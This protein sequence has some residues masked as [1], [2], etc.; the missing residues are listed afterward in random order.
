MGGDLDQAFEGVLVGNQRSQD[1]EGKH[2]VFLWQ[3]DG[4]LEQVAATAD[5][6]IGAP[7]FLVESGVVAVSPTTELLMLTPLEGTPK[8][9]ASAD[10]DRMAM[11]RKSIATSDTHVL[12]MGRIGG[13]QW[14]LYRIP[15]PR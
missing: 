1:P 10:G 12:F 9:L 14:S 15:I 3:S 13:R 6:Y 8:K 7:R 5:D 11:S 4:S 2:R